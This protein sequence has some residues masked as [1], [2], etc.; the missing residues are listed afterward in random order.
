MPDPIDT[1]NLN[2]LEDFLAA[3]GDLDAEL[4]SFLAEVTAPAPEPVAAP[5]RR[6]RVSRPNRDASQADLH[7]YLR[8][9]GRALEAEGVNY[10]EGFYVL[11]AEKLAEGRYD[12]DLADEDQV[13]AAASSASSANAAVINFPRSGSQRRRILEAAYDAG[14]RGITSDEVSQ[15]LGI[16]LQSAKPRMLELRKG[17]WLRFTGD[18]RPS[19]AGA[20]VEVMAITSR[21][22]DELGEVIST[23]LPT[24]L[25]HTK[26]S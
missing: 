10:G 9:L 17:G 26:A 13:G 24:G 11:S 12:L 14:E 15:A 25:S 2:P 22:A 20:T 19:L 1:L 8:S 4:D 18:T 3:G 5:A 21:G 6:G 7:I 23:R 16:P